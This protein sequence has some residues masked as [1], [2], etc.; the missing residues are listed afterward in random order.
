MLTWILVALAIYFASM[1]L[2]LTMNVL[3]EGLVWAASARDTPG[4]PTVAIG[5][6][7][8][9]YK[10]MQETLPVFLALAVLNMLPEAGVAQ[11]ALTGAT[12]YCLCRAVYLPLYL[13]GVPW[14]RTGVFV[15]SLIGL[16]MMLA[17]LF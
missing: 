3:K 1:F 6:A 11:S 15:L 5:R 7:E 2:H 16:L 9:A 4:T 17:A 12:I 10:N 8:R 14:L 13:A